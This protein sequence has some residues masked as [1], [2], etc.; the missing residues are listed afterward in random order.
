MIKSQFQSLLWQA[1]KFTVVDTPLFSLLN[2]P[3]VH[4]NCPAIPE[5]IP[6]HPYRRQTS[7]QSLLPAVLMIQNQTQDPL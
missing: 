2:N 5:A 4:H 6:I 1:C 7:P 3:P